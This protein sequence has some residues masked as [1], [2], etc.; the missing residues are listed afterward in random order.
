MGL[1]NQGNADACLRITLLQA[2]NAQA[3]AMYVSHQ[4]ERLLMSRTL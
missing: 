4:M 3:L 1:H 2:E